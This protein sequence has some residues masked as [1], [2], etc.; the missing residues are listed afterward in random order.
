MKSFFP[1]LLVFLFI[2]GCTGSNDLV[3]KWVFQKS[4][5]EYA[6][7]VDSLEVLDDST[8]L[9]Q[10]NGKTYNAEYR[11]LDDNRFFWKTNFEDQGT[12]SYEIDGDTL[13]MQEFSEEPE[14]GVKCYYQQQ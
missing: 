7:C 9:F 6:K 10:R 12:L 5:D 3:G 2:V 11:I 8:M 4:T 1:L 13:I 14:T